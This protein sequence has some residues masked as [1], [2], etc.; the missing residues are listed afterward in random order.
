[1]KSPSICRSVGQLLGGPFMRKLAIDLA[2]L[3]IIVE[4]GG[5]LVD[6][7]SGATLGGALVGQNVGFKIHQM[8]LLLS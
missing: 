7:P 6:G 2:H 1:M 8:I 4:L 5:L 3:W